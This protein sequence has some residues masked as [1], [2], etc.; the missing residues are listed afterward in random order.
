VASQERPVA[1]NVKIALTN[2]RVFDGRQLTRDQT[3][4]IEAGWIGNDP[5]GARVIDCGG[6]VLLPGLIDAHVHLDGPGRLE[7]L[8]SYGV[9][10]AL[11]MASVPQQTAALRGQAGQADIRS[12]GIPAIAPGSFHAHIPGVGERGLIAGAAEA[13]RFVA[14]RVAEGSDYI[15][16]VI[17]SPFADH[18]Q[19][20]IDALVAAAH[21]LGKIVV[22]HASSVASVAKAQAAG[23]D[24]LTH[25]PL[26]QALWPAAAAQAAAAGRVAVP[27]LT[28]MEGIVAG[29]APPGA[30]Y[31][32]ARAS[33]AALQVAGVPILAGTD[34]NDSAGTPV[35]IP[36]GYSLH[37]ELELLA[38]AGLSAR[39]VLLAATALPARYFGLPDRGAVEPGLRADLILIEGDP[40]QDIRATRSIRRIWCGGVEHEPAET[41]K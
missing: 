33:V 16:I 29:I 35:R 17:G 4:V 28:M 8:A 22:A 32:N 15:K 20:T 12:A 34:A 1:G 19:A 36:H 2:A 3:V 9:T 23:A 5:A 38:D 10:T 30:D 26:D 7:A 6:G 37:R 41:G 24:V 11:D 21:E 13:K 31:A 18:D 40:L 25:A 14:D 39:E 27:T